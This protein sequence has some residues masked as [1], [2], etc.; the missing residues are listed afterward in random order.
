M[1]ETA[2]DLLQVLGNPSLDL[3]S[4]V[5]VPAGV[6]GPV[7]GSAARWILDRLDFD[8]IGRDE[9]RRR[10]NGTEEVWS[11]GLLALELAG[12]IRRLP[13]GALARTMWRI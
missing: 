10:F 12:L 9:L 4:P 6:V 1:L 5:D 2:D 8:G 7:G 11:E 3:D 13:G